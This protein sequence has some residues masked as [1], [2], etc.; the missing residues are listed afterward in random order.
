MSNVLSQDEIDALLAESHG[1]DA[2]PV[3]PAVPAAKPGGVQRYDFKHPNRISKDQIRVLESIHRH[4]AGR[5][6]SALSAMMRAVVDVDVL[7]VDQVTYAEFIGSLAP[8]PCTYTFQLVPLEGLCIADYSPTLAFGFVDRVFGGRGRG[9]EAER[10]ITGI[11][12]SVMNKVSNRANKELAEGWSRIIEVEA[13]PESIENNP[14]LIQ[15]VPSGETVIVVTLEIMMLEVQGNLTFC[16]PYITLEPALAKMSGQNWFE[17]TRLKTSERDKNTLG[18]NLRLVTSDVSAVLAQ[19][20]ISLRDFLSIEVGDIL[21]SDTE[22]ISPT[23]ICIG[24]VEKYI[25]RPGV[26][27]K[28]RAVEIMAVSDADNA[29]ASQ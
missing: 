28:R 16:Y 13:I 15:I 29:T 6:A 22:T 18:E 24:G 14:Q 11:E 26:R 7:R 17:A 2:G 25:G 1:G 4:F 23:R 12:L 8:H 10:E 20:N 19:T 3:K 5:L 21:V 27:G 9:L